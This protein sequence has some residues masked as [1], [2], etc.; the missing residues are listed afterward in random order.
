MPTW[1]ARDCNVLSR[2]LTGD[3]K[4]VCQEDGSCKCDSEGAISS[5][6]GS[7]AKCVYIPNEDLTYVDT[8][9]LVVGYILFAIQALLSIAC[10]AWTVYFRNR[11]IVRASQPLFLCLIACGT[12]MMS[13]SNIPVGIQGGYRYLFDPIT[14]M[15]T[16]E[17]N[18]EIRSVDAAC[19]ALPWLFSMGFAVTFSALFAKILRIKLVFQASRN[20]VRKQ[21]GVKDVALIMVAVIALQAIVLI[22]WN[23]ADPL[24]WRREVLMEDNNGYPT[25]SIGTCSSNNG[26]AFLIP[27]IVIDALMLF[28]AL[29]LCFVTRKVS[30]E[31]QE[32]TWITASILSI[33]Q[34]LVLSIPILV[35]VDNDNSAFYFVR[36]A[37]IFLVSSTSNPGQVSSTDPYESRLRSSMNSDREKRLSIGS[38]EGITSSVVRKVAFEVDA[39]IANSQEEEENEIVSATEKKT[40]IDKCADDEV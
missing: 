17:P 29:Y 3:E 30:A 28:Y 36:V 10:T 14:G 6:V 26:L 40:E 9:L 33:L 16:D 13:F 4:G 1:D 11:R 19:M 12:F 8:S 15:Q 34:I 21:V 25:K 18:T 35:I 5:G 2:C 23:V 39:A 27:L 32:G 22:A 20:F 38:D 24:V 37:V 7:S 31:Y